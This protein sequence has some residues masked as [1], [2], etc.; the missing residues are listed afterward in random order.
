LFKNY[1]NKQAELIHNTSKT[2]SNMELIH[3]SISVFS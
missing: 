3:I 2:I 1:K